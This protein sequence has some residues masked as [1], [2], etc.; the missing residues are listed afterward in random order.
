MEASNILVA[1][2]IISITLNPLL[3]RGRVSI[4]RWMERRTP[5]LARWIRTHAAGV[6]GESPVPLPEPSGR[7]P[8]IVFGY[9]SVGQTEVRLL[10][11]NNIYVTVVEL[12]VGTVQALRAEGVR[13]IYGDA[14]RIDTLTEAGALEASVLVLTTPKIHSCHEIV[15]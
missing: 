6:A 4:E 1:A 13:A 5:R 11:E 3:Y 14:T 10:G 9:G 7:L 12:N 15:R 8:A 2:A